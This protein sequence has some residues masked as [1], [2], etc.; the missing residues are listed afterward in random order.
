VNSIKN[1]ERLQKLH[2]LIEHEQTGPPREL[3]K[4]MHVSERL[5]Y[6]LIEQLKDFSAEINYNRG[7]KTYYYVSDFTMKLNVSFSITRQ[8]KTVE[9][10][11]GSYL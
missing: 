11:Q 4:K 8:N 10:F 3:A 7:R 5:V 1:L 2:L 6:S 9:L